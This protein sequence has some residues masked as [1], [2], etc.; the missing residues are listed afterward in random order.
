MGTLAGQENEHGAISATPTKLFQISMSFNTETAGF[1]IVIAG[2]TNGSRAIESGEQVVAESG[3]HQGSYG[4]AW[5]LLIL[6]LGG[7]KIPTIVSTLMFLSDANTKIEKGKRRESI[8]YLHCERFD[9][10]DSL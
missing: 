1:S 9:G 2:P 6:Y 8:V 7:R 4:N 10:E 3:E 5:S